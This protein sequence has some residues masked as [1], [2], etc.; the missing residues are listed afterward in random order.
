MLNVTKISQPLKLWGTNEDGSVSPRVYFYKLEDVPFEQML[1]AGEWQML[2]A[3]ILPLSAA[4]CCWLLLTIMIAT[5]QATQANKANQA[6]WG[7]RDDLSNR[8]L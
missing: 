3:A 1:T 6:D 7:E 8:G 2:T 5:D 4:D